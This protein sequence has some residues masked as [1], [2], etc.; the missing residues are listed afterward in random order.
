MV[1]VEQGALRALQQDRL[2]ALQG[3]VQQQPGVGDAVLEAL[4]LLQ[5]ALDDLGRVERLAVVDLDQ[6]L[7]LELQRGL[8]LVGQLL[9]VE[10]VGDP[11]ADARDLVLVARTDAATGGADL[12]A[13]RVPFGDLVDGHVVRHEQVRV[14]R[15]HEFRGVHTAVLEPGELTEQHARVDH[16]TVADDVGD[17]GCQDARGDEVK[18]EVLPRGQ[19]H[20]VPGVVAAL[21]A[22]HP[23]HTSTE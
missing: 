3:L 13:A 16:H 15:D 19:Y 11:D 23:L 17:P 9:L 10:D 2:A 18:S 1:D 21:V 6:H 20:R 12:L 5:Q 22:N 14:S 8:D 4:G 7:V